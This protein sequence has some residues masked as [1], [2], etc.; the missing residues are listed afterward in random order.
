MDVCDN[1]LDQMFE[2]YVSDRYPVLDRL[3]SR[4]VSITGLVFLLH[5]L[6]CACAKCNTFERPYI[7]TYIYISIKYVHAVSNLTYSIATR[8]CLCRQ[9]II[10]V[11]IELMFKSIYYMQYYMY[12]YIHTFI[13]RLLD[14]LY[15]CS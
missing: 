9:S 1:L 14:V 5:I 3:D 8:K 11:Y 13:L 7:H 4:M 6:A 15:F 10:F 2:M 12:A